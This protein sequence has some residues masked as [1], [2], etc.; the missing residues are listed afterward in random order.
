MSLAWELLSLSDGVRE[1][2]RTSYGM[3][4]V[5]IETKIGNEFSNN[6]RTARHCV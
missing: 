5:V 4:T 6:R 2:V 3:L 1:D